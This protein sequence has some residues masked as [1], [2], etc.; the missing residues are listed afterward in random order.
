MKVTEQIARDYMREHL[1]RYAV[2]NDALVRLVQVE[3]PL[4]TEAS[5]DG[6]DLQMSYTAG[7]GLDAKHETTTYSIPGRLIR[8]PGAGL[9][10]ALREGVEKM[11]AE[12]FGVHDGEGL[13]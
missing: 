6:V 13:P 3:R 10:Q 11:C 5:A 12:L 9:Y 1:K 7:F 8:H 4:M 2:P